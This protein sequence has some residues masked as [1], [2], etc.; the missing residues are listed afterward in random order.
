MLQHVGSDGGSK[1]V[2]NDNNTVK[3][4]D[5]KDLRDRKTGSLPVERGASYSTAN[6]EYLI[7]SLITRRGTNKG[8][9]HLYDDNTLVRI[10][11]GKFPDERDVGQ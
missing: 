3:V 9:H 8:W 5:S 10:L 1:R 11:F 6:R 2:S 4:V 7:G